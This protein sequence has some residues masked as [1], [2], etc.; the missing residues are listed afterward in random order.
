MDRG[1]RGQFSYLRAQPPPYRKYYAHPVA[2]G[3]EQVFM[4]QLIDQNSAEITGS[5][6]Q[7]DPIDLPAGYALH[8]AQGVA[9][10]QA[11]RDHLL[12]FGIVLG[13]CHSTEL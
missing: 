11:F 10:I 3:Q 8:D 7:G 13:T 1:L 5:N 9:V 6:A 4:L 2:N 12:C